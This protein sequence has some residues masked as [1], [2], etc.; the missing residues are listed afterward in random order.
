MM[1]YKRNILILIILFFSCDNPIEA[2]SDEIQNSNNN[3]PCSLYI[4]EGDCVDINEQQCQWIALE[5]VSSDFYSCT[6][7]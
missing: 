3:D 7:I 4:Q 1:I 5:C 6:I 2:D